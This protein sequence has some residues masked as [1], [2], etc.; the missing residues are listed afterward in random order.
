MTLYSDKIPQSNPII[1]KDKKIISIDGGCGLKKDGQLNLIEIP[2]ISCDADKINT[3]SYDELPVYIAAGN[4]DGSEDS[5]SITWANNKINELECKYDFTYAEHISTGKK[6]W[7][8][9]DYIFSEHRCDDYTDYVLPVKKGDMLSIVKSTSRGYIAKKTG[10][11]VGITA[12][13]KG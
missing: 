9:N 3:Y 11:Q 10:L 4:Q 5:I 1:N 6:L 12:T 8:H 2:D 13:L 7:I